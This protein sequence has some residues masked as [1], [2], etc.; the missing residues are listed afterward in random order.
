[1]MLRISIILYLLGLLC[2][3]LMTFVKMEIPASVYY[4]WDKIAGG[5]VLLWLSFLVM[6]PKDEKIITPVLFLSIGRLLLEFI[7]LAINIPPSNDW[8]VSILFLVWTVATSFIC[9]YNGS[10]RDVFLD[11]YKPE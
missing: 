4:I 2:F 8:A 10:K 1:M 6:S 3:Y 9:L 7:I 11:K 5:G